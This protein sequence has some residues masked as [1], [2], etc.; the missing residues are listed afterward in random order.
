MLPWPTDDSRELL[1]SVRDTS[2][3]KLVRD[4]MLALILRGELG[5][6]QRINEPEVAARLQVSRVP[7]REALRELESTGLVCSRKNFGVYVRVLQAKEVADLYALRSVL[8]GHAGRCAALLEAPA[9]RRLVKSLTS[10][11]RTMQANAR[12]REVQAYYANN[13]AFHWALVEAADNQALLSSYRGI[14]QQLHLSRLK[15]LSRDIGMKSS[16]L[17]HQAIVAAIAGGN[18][19]EAAALQSDHVTASYARLVAELATANPESP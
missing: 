8:D 1:C 17:E 2:L 6:G 9:R 5:P 11:M 15:N 7:V 4:D 16:L 13:L 18:A 10:L 12:Q 14:V 19:A 3:A